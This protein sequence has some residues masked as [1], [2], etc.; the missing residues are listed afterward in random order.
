MRHRAG[1]EATP[2]TALLDSQSVKTT[3]VA[4][5]RDYDAGKKVKGRKR[6][7][8]VDTL[9]LLLAVVVHTADFQDRDLIATCMLYWTHRLGNLWDWVRGARRQQLD[10]AGTTVLPGTATQ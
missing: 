7:I 1:R 4:G 8:V 6:H 5:P 2:S 3:E 10:A 9:G